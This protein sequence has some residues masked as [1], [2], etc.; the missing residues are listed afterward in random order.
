MPPGLARDLDSPVGPLLGR[1]TAEKCEVLLLDGLWRVE[2]FR[3]TVIDG[4]EPPGLRQ[5][6]TLRV[7]NRDHRRGIE[8]VEYRLL[9]GQSLRLTHRGEALELNLSVP[10]QSCVNQGETHA[11]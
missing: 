11:H 4:G 6:M 8:G 2:L 7:R 9:Q 1:D 5:R 3:Q 10:V